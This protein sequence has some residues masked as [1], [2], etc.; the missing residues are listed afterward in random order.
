MRRPP[1]YRVCLNVCADRMK[2]ARSGTV[3]G[4]RVQDMRAFNLDY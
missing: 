3:D 1:G 4:R 2:P